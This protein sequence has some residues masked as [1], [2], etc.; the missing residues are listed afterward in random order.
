[1]LSH[2]RHRLEGLCRDKVDRAVGCASELV[3][4][5]RDGPVERQGE[6]AARLL[7]E[8]RLARLFTEGG[9]GGGFIFSKGGGG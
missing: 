9:G 8:D 2:L 4:V 6:R 3:Y 7:Q 1:V 5:G